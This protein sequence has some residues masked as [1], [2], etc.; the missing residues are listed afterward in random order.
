M[1]GRVLITG[2]A[3]FIG[4]R[5]ARRL[6]S[7]GWDVLCYDNLHPQVHG[8]NRNPDKTLFGGSG[9]CLVVGDVTRAADLA[10]CMRSFDP[11]VI[12]HLA[13]ETGTGQS[14]D[15]PAR[16]NAVNVM[17]T[18]N[19]IEAV[20]SHGR[21][22]ARILVAGSRSIYGEGA[23]RTKDGTICNAQPRD[24]AAMKRGDF[25]IKDQSGE[26]LEPVPTPE[27]LSPM[28]ASVY[29]S[30]KLMQEYL[31]TQCFADTRVKVGVLRLQN[32]FGPGQSLSNPYTGVISIFSQLV[33]SGKRL[34]IFED[35]NIMRD[36][37]FIDDV[38]NAFAAAGTSPPCQ[39]INIGSGMAISIR[40]MARELLQML[41][42]DPEDHIVSGDFRIGDVRHAVAD[43]SLARRTL[44]W[45][46]TVNFQDGLK[47]F[48]E[49][50][51]GNA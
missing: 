32:V 12:Y 43:V 23:G 14:Y 21:N 8:A 7:E 31:L 2:G 18:A 44:N 26:T 33:T 47:Q 9:A 16:Y 36:F 50:S 27:W 3:G 30:T 39:P 13:A 10:S 35:G 42:N 15:E 5:L 46:P 24:P 48:L 45:T 49:W 25:S 17:G 11:Q 6:L 22:V 37:V 41:G 19:L 38:V 34:N 40:D 51:A 29:A 28:P 1:S 20:R 4:S